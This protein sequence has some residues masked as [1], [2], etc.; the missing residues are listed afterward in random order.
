M[1]VNLFG[2]WQVKQEVLLLWGEEDRILD[3]TCAEVSA[4]VPV[5]GTGLERKGGGR[6]SS[7][8]AAGFKLSHG[9]G[10]EQAL[11]L[12]LEDYS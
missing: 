12:R 8:C 3:Q 11:R 5:T 9:M 2:R 1:T 7:F 10:G 6:R 4:A